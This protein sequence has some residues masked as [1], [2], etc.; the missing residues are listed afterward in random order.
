MRATCAKCCAN[1]HDAGTS[2]SGPGTHLKTI[3][4][5]GRN[6]QVGHELVSALAPLGKVIALGRA[7]LDLARPDTLAERIRDIQ[8]DIIVNAAA[9]TAV[10]DAEAEP[11]LA[12]CI[13]AEAPALMAEEAR[14]SGAL[15][16]HYST[17]YVFDGRKN[18]TYTEDDAPAPLNAYGRSKLAGEQRIA[19]TGCRHLIFRTS[20]LYADRGTNFL[21]TM[22]QLARQRPALRVVADQIGSPTWAR[23]LAAATVTALGA[24]DLSGKLGIYHLSA[25]GH[26]SRYAFAEEIIR[27]ATEISGTATGWATLA[28]CTTDEFPRPAARPL[29]AAA[30]KD[31]FQRAFGNAMP[32]W[33]TQLRDCMLTLRW[34]WL[35]QPAEV[36]QPPV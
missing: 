17:D 25:D 1:R 27:L 9:Y 8:P 33:T 28:P 5:T 22:L 12:M 16:V 36:R 26:A 15:L 23:A 13:N 18:G 19:A 32:H 3:L 4:L 20:W 35:H 6:G 29:N 34:D 2:G 7:E 14:R 21:L 30:A 11:G 31:K 24:P 10:D